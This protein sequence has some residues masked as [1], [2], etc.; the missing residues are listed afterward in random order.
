MSAKGSSS[1][2]GKVAIVFETPEFRC[3]SEP[4]LQPKLQH[5]HPEA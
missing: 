5:Q 4:N 1:D 2:G 3:V